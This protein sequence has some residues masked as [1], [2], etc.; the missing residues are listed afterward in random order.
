V[1]AT[2]SLLGHLDLDLELDDEFAIQ[3]SMRTHPT[4]LNLASDLVD[5]PMPASTKT[6]HLTTHINLDPKLP[7]FFPRGS[8]IG[9]AP[10]KGQIKDIFDVVIKNGWSWRDPAV[11]F[12]RTQTEEDIRKRWDETK[13][14]LTRDWKKR[15]RE[16]GK[17]KKRR[18][19]GDL[20]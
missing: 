12:W 20:D 6:S 4:S 7:L 13:V 14:E 1:L 15:W 8:S 17:M 9:N 18:G 16:A 5:K 11:G 2:F 3:T 19:G 10:T